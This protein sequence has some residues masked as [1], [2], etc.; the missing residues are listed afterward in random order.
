MKVAAVHLART[1]L[2]H[3]NS[4]TDDAGILQAL[5]RLIERMSHYDEWWREN[6]DRLREHLKQPAPH[7]E[8]I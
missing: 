3:G 4:A 5:E 6:G 7:P 1:A 2:M 8:R